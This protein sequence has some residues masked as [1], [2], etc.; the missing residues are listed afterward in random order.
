[1]P[2]RACPWGIDGGIRCVR[3]ASDEGRSSSAVSWKG[4]WRVGAGADG[5]V[6]GLIQIPHPL[7]DIPRLVIRSIG[8]RRIGRLERGIWIQAAVIEAHGRG[9]ASER[10]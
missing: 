5:V 6:V 7:R 8:T 9:A 3:S 4:P 1:M 10:I 2:N